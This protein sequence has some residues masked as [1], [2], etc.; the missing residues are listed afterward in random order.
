MI[1]EDEK[2]K[3]FFF[4]LFQLNEKEKEDF[5][6]IYSKFENIEIQSI[7]D[8]IFNKECLIKTCIF[9]I[10]IN[11]KKTKKYNEKEYN[12]YLEKLYTP[13]K[14]QL[15]YGKDNSALLTLLNVLK[16]IKNYI[17]LSQ[18]RNQK[19]FI[20]ANK[21]L[22]EFSQSKNYS[23]K[24]DQIFSNFFE[25]SENNFKLKKSFW[26][27]FIYIK[28]KLYKDCRNLL[29]GFKLL[30]L[31]FNIL[32]NKIPIKYFPL[33]LKI[34]EENK[35]EIIQKIIFENTKVDLNT[36]S[37]EDYNQVIIEINEIKINSLNYE[38]N[39]KFTNFFYSKY[40]KEFILNSN[41]FDERILFF[42]IFS[43]KF[44]SPKKINQ[45]LAPFNLNN[46]ARKLFINSNENI[47]IN[48]NNNNININ[49]NNNNKIINHS[50][51]QINDSIYMT[52]FTRVVTLDKWLK[53][54]IKDY[55][56]N[57][58][59]K[60]QEKYS[61]KYDYNQ[62]LKPISNYINDI[63]NNKFQK[64]LSSY[65]VKLITNL[66]EIIKFCLKFIQNLI[67][68]D[69]NIFTEE[70]CVMLLYNE[71]FLKSMIALSFEIIL[72][73]EDI[74]EIPFNKIYETLELDIYDFWK[75]LNP[76]QN[77]VIIFHKEIKDHLD[78]IEYQILSFLIWRN[79]SFNFKNDINK[80][81]TEEMN[82]ELKNDIEKLS[83][84]EFK[85]QSLFL[86]HNKEDYL[87]DFIKKEE[88]SKLDIF[89]KIR[90][91]IKSYP[92]LNGMNIFFR[93]V[94]N[95]C[96]LLNK[97]IF[98]NLNLSNEIAVESEKFLKG[99]LICEEYIKIL[100]QH[101]IDQFVI[102][103]II[104]ILKMNN[105]FKDEKNINEDNEKKY[106][107]RSIIT[108]NDIK[109]SYQQSKT[110]KTIFTKIFTHVK[111]I[112]NN[113]KKYIS[114]I[115]F[116]YE[117][118]IKIFDKFI[119]NFKQEKE[120]LQNENPIKK[121]KL[122]DGIQI[123]NNNTNN[124][125]INSNQEILLTKSAFSN[126]IENYPPNRKKIEK[127]N[128]YSILYFNENKPKRTQRLKEIY[129]DIINFETGSLKSNKTGN[130]LLKL[131]IFKGNLF[132]QS[133]KK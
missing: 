73:I 92:Y 42:D 114:L 29:Q 33:N 65:R 3:L 61:P 30:V 78:E 19:E 55:D 129:A 121:R 83:D 11:S 35:K 131:N 48:N 9:I 5:S 71:I 44:S 104:T 10:Y 113:E 8:K 124:K 6:K 130:P 67:Q 84:F 31:I 59:L 125:K 66:E 14:R 15:I 74:E 24:L 96:N 56:Y 39:F 118:F 106:D 123:F 100:F 116:Y 1:S 95:Y 22:E 91:N 37:Q 117:Y 25:S 53:D 76:T 86:L 115:D 63:L 20:L 112:D 43:K 12:L 105:L 32:I 98:Q 64:L 87:L 77:H 50:N 82:D 119:I 109:N 72:F 107:F 2:I 21:K 16:N 75:I 7:R 120:N 127:Q 60:L 133:K 126:K 81:F 93:R 27:A 54:Y 132:N 62:D 85:N 79:P 28:S 51:I 38:N 46:C 102:C 58:I 26:A 68:N 45:F 103:V 57:Y 17:S 101:H 23:R 49:I 36:I 99:I 41:I 18:I 88:K 34:N 89:K 90:D 13:Y 97:D 70:F 122:S 108:I 47:N 80:L 4:D 110:D 40:Q 128:L 52:P 69:E 94:I 111:I